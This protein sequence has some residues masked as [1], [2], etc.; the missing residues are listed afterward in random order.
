VGHDE[1]RRDDGRAQADSAA[2]WRKGAA[3]WQ[4]PARPYGNPGERNPGPSLRGPGRVAD[5]R[6]C[7]KE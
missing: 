3:P 1:V 7:R 2:D 5:A 4:A 6:S